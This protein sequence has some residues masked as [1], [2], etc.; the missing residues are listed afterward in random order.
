VVISKLTALVLALAVAST[1]SSSF[2]Q[3]NKTR[4]SAAR[5]QA[6]AASE[7]EQATAARE[8]A[9]HECSIAA[10]KYIEHVWADWDIQIYRSCM[11]RRGQQE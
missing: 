9:I 11:A 6:I 4:A 2:A 5:E 7:Q 1:A 8:D 3:A 10:A